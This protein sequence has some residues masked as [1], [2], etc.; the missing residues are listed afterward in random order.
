MSF[1][2]QESLASL[3][4]KQRRVL[5]DKQLVLDAQ[6]GSSAAFGQIQTNYR[7]QLYRSILA[8][9]RNHE[10]AEDALQDTFLRAYTALPYFQGRSSVYSWLTR[11]AINSALMVLRKRRVRAE[12]CL[13][14][15]CE[16]TGAIPGLELRDRAANPEQLCDQ[17]E[18]SIGLLRAIRKLD[19]KLRAPLEIQ[20]TNQPSMKEMAETL[21]ISLAAVKAR[22]HRARVRIMATRAARHSAAMPISNPL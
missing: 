5:R 20:L 15:Q 17:R 4:F 8:I 14:P 10:D 3:D 22:L 2:Q 12:I 16:E 21:N 13:D 11:I 6:R 19:P 9:T 18:R 1:T 7:S